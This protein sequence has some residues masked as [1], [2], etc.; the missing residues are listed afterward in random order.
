M[1]PAA[2]H[3]TLFLLAGTT[4]AAAGTATNPLLAP[5]SGGAL[6]TEAPG[7]TMLGTSPVAW[8]EAVQASRLRGEEFFNTPFVPAP[9]EATLRDGLGPLYNSVS[10]ESCHN[11]L[12][13][14]RP[15]DHDGRPSES[16]VVQLSVRRPDGSDGPHPRYG[17][18]FNP[19]A[20]PGVPAEGQVRISYELVTGR[21]GDGS[22]W[23]IRK[24]AYHFEQLAYGSIADASF[25]PRMAQPLI[26]LGLLDAI[27]EADILAR[28]DPD[29]RNHDGISGRPNWIGGEGT[30]PRLGRYGW[31]AN[32]VDIRAQTKAAFLSE[33][34]ISSDGTAPSNCAPA[35]AACLAA[36]VGGDPEISNAALDAI[37]TFL[38]TVPVPARRNLD[39]DAVK[40]GA[41]L[42]AEAGCQACHVPTW[43]T[44]PDAEL[45]TLANQPIHPYTDLLLHDMGPGLADGRPDH[46]ATGSEWRTPPLWGI[47]R[48][49]ELGIPP[50][51]L[52][53]GRARTLEEAVLW[54]GGE[55]AAARA[56]FV[57]WGRGEREALLAFLGSL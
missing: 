47:G 56:A 46:E 9:S 44:G 27:A 5:T 21:Y 52:H 3:L 53:D 50:N 1:P 14:G 33:Q 16:L 28:A 25:S 20:I 24:P 36:S 22:A 43:Q 40:R 32:Q 6:T 37:V 51:Y 4:V 7:K 2:R 23:E 49:A 38:R 39:S 15:A 13:R 57:G 35:Q 30:R 17:A 26:G 45:P 54:H 10:C 29:D 48:T 19:Q 41:A 12:G 42:F 8:P 55:A 18:N 31:K 34:G 11:N